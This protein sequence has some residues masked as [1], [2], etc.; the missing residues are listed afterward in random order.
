MKRQEAGEA[1]ARLALE[2]DCAAIRTKQ[3]GHS[4]ANYM[5]L[6]DRRCPVGAGL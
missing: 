4:H 3:T 2:R 1:P 5:E 6:K